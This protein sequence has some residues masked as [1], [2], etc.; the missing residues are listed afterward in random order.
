MHSS[1]GP[2]V[3]AVVADVVVRT[4][5]FEDTVGLP[6]HTV[7]PDHTEIVGSGLT[8]EDYSYYHQHDQD[9]YV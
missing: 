6:D 7:T 9:S 1:A 8:A 2:T 5:E 3:A 4:A